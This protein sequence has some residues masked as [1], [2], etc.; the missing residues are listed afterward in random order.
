LSDN[1]IL[2]Y[3]SD[4]GSH[5]RTRNGE[6]KRACHDGC[7]R[8]PLIIQGPG[9]E[10]GKVVDELVSLVDLPPT[11]LTAAGLETPDYMRGEPLQGLVDGTVDKWP[12][13]VFLQIS[14]NHCGR[15]IRSK[16]WK[17][18]VRA[19]EKTGQD[20]DSEIYVEDFLYDLEHDPHELHNLVA[21]S[22]LAEIRQELSKTLKQRM[23]QAG[24]QKPKILR[25]P[26]STEAGT[27]ATVIG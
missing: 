13:E 20:P 19:P 2:V 27:T 18:S 24:E 5:F 3:T 17:Y 21:S 8:I 11:V 16:R 15:A 7:I 9:F 1:T 23:V 14:E 22:H 26:S 12:Q 4:H 25:A 10:G 6:Y